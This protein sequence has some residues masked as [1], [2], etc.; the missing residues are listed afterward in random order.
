MPTLIY[1]NISLCLSIYI[2][3]YIAYIRIFK[4]MFPSDMTPYLSYF[5][6][7]TLTNLLPRARAQLP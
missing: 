7:E 5:S 4:L 2:K 3:I 6:T 1:I